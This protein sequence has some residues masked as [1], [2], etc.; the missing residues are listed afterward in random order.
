AVLVGAQSVLVVDQ[1]GASYLLGYTGNFT[2]RS[3]SSVTAPAFAASNGSVAVVASAT[4]F[5][6]AT[7]DAGQN[8][9]TSTLGSGFAALHSLV[10]HPRRGR[11][12][13]YGVDGSSARLVKFSND[14]FSWVTASTTLA[15][16]RDAPTMHIHSAVAAA[17]GGRMLVGA[18]GAAGSGAYAT[19]R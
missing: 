4:G 2:A 14:G 16:P 13:A 3:A 1:G 15:K 5:A 7:V 8:W 11:F 12:Y 6:N 17:A 9:V 18:R 19:T 10:W